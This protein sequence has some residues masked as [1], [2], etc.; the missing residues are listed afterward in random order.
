MRPFTS[1]ITIDEARR[2][3]RDGV[4]PITSTERLTLETAAGRVAAAD[5]RS[6]AFVPPFSRYAMDGYA[7]IAADTAAAT[8][9]A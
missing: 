7:V 2:R 5:L 4:R 6:A 8:A 1:T 9:D 3:L